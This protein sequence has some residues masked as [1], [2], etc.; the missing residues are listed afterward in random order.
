M[1]ISKDQLKQIIKEEL[2]T[3]LAEGPFDDLKSKSDDMFSDMDAGIS[4]IKKDEP[5]D[6]GT[7]PLD[8]LKPLDKGTSPLAGTETK[9][10][11]AA[12]DAPSN[13]KFSKSY[14]DMDAFERM[15]VDKTPI[16]GFGGSAIE[17]DKLGKE[18]V[19]KVRDA[20]G[21]KDTDVYKYNGVDMQFKDLPPKGVETVFNMK[22][23]TQRMMKEN[24]TFDR[25]K[26]LING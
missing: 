23:Q 10:P 2:K 26:K 9:A 11:P 20:F 12:P 25:W 4:N 14:D 22:A 18:M 24:K 7:S 17:A 21:I 16:T 5:F 3:V 13:P 8:N 15:D 19:P 6:F 1:K